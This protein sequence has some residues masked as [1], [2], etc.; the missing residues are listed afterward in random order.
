MVFFSYYAFVELFLG[1]FS[2][3]EFDSSI[4]NLVSRSQQQHCHFWIPKLNTTWWGKP[5]LSNGDNVQ[6][7]FSGR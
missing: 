3:S 6:C 4:I 1:L 5:L 2:C 7:G